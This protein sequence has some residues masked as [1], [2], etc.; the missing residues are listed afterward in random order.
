[1]NNISVEFCDKVQNLL[2]ATSR[3]LQ[4]YVKVHN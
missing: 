2:L 1:M 4:F 3:P